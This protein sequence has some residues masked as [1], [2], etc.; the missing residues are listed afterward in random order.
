MK[1]GSK[2]SGKTDFWNRYIDTVREK[3]RR[4]RALDGRN[5]ER[6]FELMNDTFTLKRLLRMD[7]HVTEDGQFSISAQD[8]NGWTLSPDELVS[9]LF[10]N[11]ERELYGLLAN[12]G[13]QRLNLRADQLLHSFSAPHPYIAYR[14]HYRA[15]R[16]TYRFF[17]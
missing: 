11:N 6:E 13:E 9:F 4:L 10:F 8:K 12:T 1:A 7:M 16:R 3:N 2:K 15:G 14:R 17:P 5:G